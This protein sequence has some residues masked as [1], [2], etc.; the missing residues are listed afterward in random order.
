MHAIIWPADYLPGMTENFAS[1]EI[2]VAGLSVADVW[3]Q[4]DDT[5]AWP[6]YYSNAVDIRFYDGK[7]PQLSAGA[8]FCFTT[9]G[10]PVEAEVTEYVAPA[11]GQP[12]RMAWHGW[13]E[14]RRDAP[15]R[16][17]RLAV[18]GPARRAGA[19]PHPGNP[20]RATGRGTGQGQ[21]QPDDQRPP[22]MDRGVGRRRP[23]RPHL[24]GGCWTRG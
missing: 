15:G 6:G 10:F 21:A 18:R 8:R 7:G 22:G 11:D 9:F 24:N 16:A 17:P 12:A 1:N 5:R 19:H 2:I 3:P 14:R 20:E 13:V 23:A 4:L